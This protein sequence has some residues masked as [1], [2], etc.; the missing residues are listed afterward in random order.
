MAD[1]LGVPCRHRG[2]LLGVWG[3]G[4]LGFLVLGFRD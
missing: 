2:G 3:F 4:F 1:E